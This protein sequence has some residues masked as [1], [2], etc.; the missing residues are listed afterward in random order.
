MEFMKLLQRVIDGRDICFIRIEAR[1]E[2]KR[3]FMHRRLN[4]R[5]QVMLVVN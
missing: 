4:R 3:V 1:A 2:N 5:L